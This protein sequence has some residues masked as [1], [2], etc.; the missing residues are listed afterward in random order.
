MYKLRLV[1]S[2]LI[3]IHVI[4]VVLHGMAHAG[5]NVWADL[6]SGVFIGVVIVIAPLVALYLLYTRWLRWGALLLTLAMLGAL[7]FGVWEHFLLPGT[8]NIAVTQPGIWQWPF[9][10]T[11]VL[12]S[13]I[14][15]AGTLAGAWLF[16]AVRH[17]RST[18]QASPSRS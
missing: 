2:L 3:C 13:L 15:A 6:F 9:R 11:A 4:V 18:E 7:L 16:L 1:A 14:E 8:D 17:G 12:L 5:I 10:L